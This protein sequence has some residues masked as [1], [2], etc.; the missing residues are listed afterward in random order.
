ML[1]KKNCNASDWARYVKIHGQ[2]AAILY[3]WQTSLMDGLPRPVQAQNLSGHS[4]L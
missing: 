3:P 2:V 1:F 4:T